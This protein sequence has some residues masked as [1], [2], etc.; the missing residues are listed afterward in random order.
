MMMGQI[1]VYSGR[2]PRLLSPH[3]PEPSTTTQTIS[4]Q[5]VAE[6]IVREA[7]SLP[8]LE[9]VHVKGRVWGMECWII[10]NHSTEEERFSL[11]DLEWQMMEQL[12]GVGFKFNLIDRQG[13]PLDMVVTLEPAD[14]SIILPKVYHA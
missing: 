10:V 7:V 11:Y 1:V 14:A 5:A 9:A 12:R 2:Q 13:R 8:S 6:Q 4:P 3:T